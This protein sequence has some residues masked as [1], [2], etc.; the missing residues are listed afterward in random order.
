MAE[1]ARRTRE[2]EGLDPERIPFAELLESRE[3][4]ILKG[5]VKDWEIGRRGAQSAAAAIDYLASFDG[6]R[7]AEA[8]AL[9]HKLTTADTLDDFL[10]LPAYERLLELEILHVE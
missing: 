2:I 4:A 10:T 3:P 5:V 9:F 8:N 1:V 6:G 7:F